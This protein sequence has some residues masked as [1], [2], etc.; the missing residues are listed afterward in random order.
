MTIRRRSRSLH[1]LGIAFATLS[2]VAASATVGL[3]AD[4]KYKL[5]WLFPIQPPGSGFYAF[6]AAQALGFWQQEGLQVDFK[7]AGGSGAAIQLLIAGHADAGIPSMPAT[8][9]AAGRGQKLNAFYQYS[10]GTLFYLK[11]PESSQVKSVA[12]LKGKVIGISE[13]GGGEVPMVKAAVQGAR[14]DP[15]KDVRLVPIGEGSPATF[16]AIRSGKVDAY[17]SNF[18]DNLAV[19][20]AGI[21]LRDITPKE[22]SAFPAQ[23]MIVTPQSLAKNKPALTILA[24]GVA[25]GSFWCQRK[26]AECE[27]MLR[28]VSKEEWANPQV[29]KPLFQRALEI[30]AI[31]EG[32]RIGEPVRDNLEKYLGFLKAQNPKFNPPKVEEFLVTD[33]LDEINRFDREAVLK[34]QYKP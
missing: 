18:Q 19:E 17:A 22:F 25:K 15:D 16:E 29:A 2:L 7:S 24:R 21:K 20:L 8:L 10:T 33:M 4:A 12:D 3:A 30:T 13:P 5:T 23:M 1:I 9:N 31:R 26:P 27:A 32:K 11:V 6:L 14:L 34:V 28:N